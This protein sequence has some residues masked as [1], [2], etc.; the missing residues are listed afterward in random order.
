MLKY[1]ERRK[2]VEV[3]SE[4]CKKRGYKDSCLKRARVRAKIGAR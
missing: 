4:L 1:E 3:L 2:S